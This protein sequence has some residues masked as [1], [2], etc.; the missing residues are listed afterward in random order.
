MY[1]TLGLS[2]RQSLLVMVHVW[3]SPLDFKILIKMHIT[4]LTPGVLITFTSV[5]LNSS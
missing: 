2:L 4:F 5:L 1:W 3:T